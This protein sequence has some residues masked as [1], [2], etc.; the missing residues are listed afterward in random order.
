MTF[1][2]NTL[3]KPPDKRKYFLIPLVK[4][5]R[6][7]VYLSWDQFDRLIKAA[8]DHLKWDQ[9]TNGWEPDSVIEPD[10]AIVERYLWTY[11]YTG[12]RDMTIVPLEWGSGLTSGSIDAPNGIIYRSPPGADETNKRVEPSHL[13]P[14]MAK[15][16]KE[17]E[18][19]DQLIRCPYVFH[20]E[21]GEAIHDMTSRFERL[22][23][24]AG[25]PWVN[26]H[27]LKHTGVTLLTH[28]GLDSVSLA[29]AFSTFPETLG[30]EYRHLQ[31]L[32]I[33]ARTSSQRN[34]KLEW[35]DLKRTSPESSEAWLARAD[36]IAAR[37]E[38]RAR[39]KQEE[40]MQ[41]GT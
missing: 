29:V 40:A 17:W 8:R 3:S 12:T 18:R 32:W 13:L 5:S 9:T 39:R 37:A 28:A 15:M 31:F 34:L 14:P 23:R 27:V 26:K 10:L 36:L 35:K 16:V 41:S 7:E 1:Y 22:C 38:R 21:K 6:S 25:L 19:A 4:N 11:F 24:K 20:D 30:K 2:Y 33:K